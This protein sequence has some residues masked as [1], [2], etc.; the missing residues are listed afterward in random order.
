MIFCVRGERGGWVGF[1]FARG[2]GVGEGWAYYLL[3]YEYFPCKTVYI[4]NKNNL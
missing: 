4:E 1:E 3:Q 2:R